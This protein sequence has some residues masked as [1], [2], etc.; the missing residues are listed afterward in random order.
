M[1]KGVFFC[2][3]D[4]QNLFSDLFNNGIFLSNEEKEFA[5][6]FSSDKEMKNRADVILTHKRVLLLDYE[7]YSV[8]ILGN[9]F[10][11]DVKIV[12]N[13][14]L[15]G[16]FRLKSWQYKKLLSII[17]TGKDTR[18]AIV[19]KFISQDGDKLSLHHYSGAKATIT[20]DEL[21]KV[22][23]RIE[24]VERNIRSQDWA[25]DALKK[26]KAK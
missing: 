25:K 18:K 11:C 24:D 12:E 13:S 20:I 1:Q 17:D 4:L 7:I 8:A 14:E 2:S 21:R 23:E 5:K 3:A 16:I 9:S 19:G 26:F 10:T 22:V 6:M 15:I